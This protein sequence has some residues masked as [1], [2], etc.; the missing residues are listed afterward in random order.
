M[1]DSNQAPNRAYI[2]GHSE[3]ELQRLRDQANLLAPITR[4][5]LQE[6]G[7][8]EGMRVLDVGSGTGGV[9]VL[10]AELVGP[11]GAVVGTD[12]APTAVA[13]ATQAIQEQG[14]RNVTIRQGNPAE[15]SFDAPFDAVVGRYVLP[16][17]NDPAAMLRGLAQHVVKDGLLVFHEPDWSCVRSF[18]PCPLYDAACRWIIETTR[19]S[20]QSWSFLDKVGPAFAQAELPTPTLR[21]QTYVSPAQHAQ[22]WL[23]AVG[24]MVESLLPAIERHKLATM[25]EVD[26]PTLRDRLW[27]EVTESQSTIVGR[28][29]IGMWTRVG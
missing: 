21:M 2:L 26:V 25:E 12:M 22:P 6:A 23:R 4:R 10:A 14:L 5:F 19:L 7:I 27:T 17:Q 13:A 8:K 20:G 29:E 9:A 3:Q 18:P 11:T 24:D 16:F 1:T 28:S 15:L